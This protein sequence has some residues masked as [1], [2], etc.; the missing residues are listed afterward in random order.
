MSVAVVPVM[1]TTSGGDSTGIAPPLNA[2]DT[3]NVTGPGTVSN[4]GTLIENTRFPATA[5]PLSPSS[6][7]VPGSSVTR[8]APSTRCRMTV[9]GS[10]AGSMM[11]AVT[12]TTA[13]TPT[14]VDAGSISV[15][16]I[17]AGDPDGMVSSRTV[18]LA[19]LVRP[20]GLVTTAVIV[21]L[22]SNSATSPANVPPSTVAGTSLIRTVATGPV[23]VPLTFTVP[24][25]KTLSGV[26]AAMLMLRSV[27]TVTAIDDERVLPAASVA[28]ML[29]ECCPS[30]NER[31]HVNGP[32]GGTIALPLHTEPATPETASLMVPVTTTAEAS[33]TA[34]SA[35]AVMS[36]CGTVLSRLMVAVAVALLPA[37]SVT[38]RAIT[39]P[40]PSVSTRTAGGHAPTPL[41]ASV[42]TKLTVTSARFQPALLGG[43]SSP[44]VIA[45]VMSS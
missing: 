2:A 12:F 25:L 43:G 35:G 30:L 16:P 45:G 1:S 39:W 37:A 42:H 18:T 11:A 28:A 13:A 32:T 38:V 20:A 41:S 40:A 24:V 26:G 7:S 22:P 34:P 33:S 4:T 19:V 31:L 6:C 44:V 3:R 10:T 36:I 23:T 15:S 14:G 21:L 27:A 9:S 5:S 17:E 8:P 29:I